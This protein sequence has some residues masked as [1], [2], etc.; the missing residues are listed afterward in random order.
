MEDISLDFILSEKFKFWD[1]KEFKTKKGEILIL[2]EIPNYEK[3]IKNKKQADHPSL[4]NVLP[5]L[6]HFYEEPLLEKNQEF[7]LFRKMNFYKKKCKDFAKK[8]KSKEKK[9][10]FNLLKKH[11]GDYLSIRELIV[12]CNLRLSYQMFKHRKDFYGQNINDLLSDCFINIIKA[13]D[14]FDYTRGIK[15]S[16]YCTWCL[17]NNSIRDQ[18][19]NKKFENFVATN[20]ENTTFESSLDLKDEEIIETY[21]KNE[22]LSY[23]W[24]KIKIVL[25]T[26]SNNRDYYILTQIFGIGENGVTIEQIGIKYD[27]TKERIRQIKERAIKRLQ[28]ARYSNA[29]KA[30]L[31]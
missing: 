29:L 22:S 4:K 23:D 9:E 17:L 27:L 11:Y 20:L 16:T 26:S 15:F 24:N 12:K 19:A 14:G 3:F 10:F 13:V 30:Y 21:D 31:G 25:E 18:N 28:K 7:H 8:Y 1:T 2:S 5:E 6:K